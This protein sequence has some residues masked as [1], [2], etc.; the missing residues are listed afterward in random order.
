MSPVTPNSELHKNIE[1]IK[2]TE[3]KVKVIERSGTRL[4]DLLC[5]SN[6]FDKDV[7]FDAAVCKLCKIKK[8]QCK[9]REVVYCIECNDCNGEFK[10]IGE[11]SRSL[12]ERFDER[13]TNSDDKQSVFLII[14]P[15]TTMA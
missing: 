4:K 8:G 13:F 1:K 2:D 5:K 9:K 11:T 12:G 10:Y 14:K 6:P 3:L 15:N 7:C